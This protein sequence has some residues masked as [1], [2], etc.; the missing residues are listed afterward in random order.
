MGPVPAREPVDH[1]AVQSLSS[2]DPVLC[3]SSSSTGGRSSHHL[4]PLLPTDVRAAREQ[5]NLGGVSYPPPLPLQEVQPR[6]TSMYSQVSSACS[7]SASF[8]GPPGGGVASPQPHSSYFSGL[9]GPQHPFYNR[10]SADSAPCLWV[11]KGRL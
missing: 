8:T 10:V 9:A 6:P 2:L 3:C 7:P 11:N 4:F 5:M 1:L